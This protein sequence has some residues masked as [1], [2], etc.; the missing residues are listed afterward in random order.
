VKAR[1]LQILSG[2]YQNFIEKKRN[3]ENLK[4]IGYFTLTAITLD[5]ATSK[6][7]PRKNKF[8]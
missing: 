5:G 1:G 4:L 6:N 7:C 3:I 2:Y 8:R